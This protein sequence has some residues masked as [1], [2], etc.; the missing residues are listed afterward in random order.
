MPKYLQS[1][2][3]GGEKIIVN[4]DL[5]VFFKASL[6]EEATEVWFAD[7][8]GPVKVQVPFAKMIELLNITN[9]A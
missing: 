1:I 4:L 2:N 7:A 5:V 6:D 9:S 8:E 3:E